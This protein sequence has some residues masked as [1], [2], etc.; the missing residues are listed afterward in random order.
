[1]RILFN[2]WWPDSSFDPTQMSSVRPAVAHTAADHRK[3]VGGVVRLASQFALIL[4]GDCDPSARLD[5]EL[6]AW[7]VNVD[8]RSGAEPWSKE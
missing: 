2:L 6:A 7:T 3:P 8:G 4:S 5:W 1:M